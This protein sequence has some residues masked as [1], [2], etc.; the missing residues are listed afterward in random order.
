MVRFKNRYLLVEVHSDPEESRGRPLR[1]ATTHSLLL[2]VRDAVS[3]LHGDYGLASVYR[4]LSVKYLNVLTGVAIIRC[5]SA[6]HRSVWAAISS[7]TSLQGTPCSISLIHLGG[8]IRS[9]QRHL[10]IYNRVQLNKML[11]SAKTPIE[12]RELTT[13]MEQILGKDSIPIPV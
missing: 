1:G 12:R 8:T 6:H 9:C 2:S 13:R 11:T 10:V 7:I 3:A 4:S 5:P